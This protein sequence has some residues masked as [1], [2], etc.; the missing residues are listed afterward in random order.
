[1]S[2]WR[3]APTLGLLS[4]VACGPRVPSGRDAM[5]EAL[6]DGTLT[7]SEAR[8]K[9]LFAARCAA[10]HGA[11][12]RGDGPNASRLSPVPPDMSQTLS[13][14]PAADRR[15]IVVEGTAAVG[16]SALC[17]PHGATLRREEVD[18][19]MAWL[20]VAARP[21]AGDAEPPAPRRRRRPTAGTV[22]GP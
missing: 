11:S 19:L 21:V 15:R 9:R 4:L 16:R 17:P 7:A 20:E 1:M 13:T 8:G 12:G 3:L 2:L 10:C 5:E 18:A 22:S 14:L 6:R